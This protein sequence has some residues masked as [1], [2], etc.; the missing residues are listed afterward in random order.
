M[1]PATAPPTG[2][3]VCF[4]EKMNARNLS[5]ARSARMAELDGVTCP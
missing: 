1:A 5:G 2:T 3:P 4:S